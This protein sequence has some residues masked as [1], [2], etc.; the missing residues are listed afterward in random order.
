MIPVTSYTFAYIDSQCR[1]D[2]RPLREGASFLEDGACRNDTQPHTP[3]RNNA[4]TLLSKRFLLAK[5]SLLPESSPSPV[6][7]VA[8][9]V[10]SA[11]TPRG[12]LLL[13]A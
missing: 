10:D 4:A 8:I 3:T 7:A 6:P 2:T 9:S 5:T 11:G 13:V 12:L 1:S